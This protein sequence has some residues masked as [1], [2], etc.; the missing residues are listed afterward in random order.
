MKNVLI[1]C[2]ADPKNDPR[3]NRMINWL[4]DDFKLTI[5]TKSAAA[6]E[7]IASIS[8]EAPVRVSKLIKIAGILP[9]GVRKIL[10]EPAKK[11]LSLP[12]MINHLIKIKTGRIEDLLWSIHELTRKMQQQLSDTAFDLII[13][14]DCSLLPLALGLKKKNSK[15]ML[16]AREYYPK[17]YDDQWK[18]RLQQRPINEYLCKQYLH[19]CDKIITVSDGLARE[20][21]K[22]YHVQPEVVMSLPAFHDIL[23]A[24]TDGSKIRMIYHG[25][26]SL[27]RR[28][29]VMI[30]LMGHV[31]ERFS[32]D[33]MVMLDKSEYAEKFIS[34][35]RG[36]RNIRLI[37][38][39]SMQQLVPLT[40]TYDI[41]L[42]LC[43]PT[44]LNLKYALPNKL[45]EFIQARLMVAIGPGIEMRKIVEKYD[46]GIV[47]EDFNP[48]SLARKLNSLTT[49]KVMYYKEQSNTAAHELNEETNR[50]RI[51][52]IV[53]DLIGE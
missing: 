12:I 24:K 37:P 1:V 23:P 10:K 42:F 40:N 28:T 3:P 11:I 52:E 15:V 49:Q 41:G 14:H 46:C 32:L 53:C 35:V 45:F 5:I 22:E 13:T 9:A 50:K 44:N 25:W 21:F 31:D 7:G 4:K 51:R 43:P 20:Y 2:E 33:L 16:D 30:D 17:N 39:V 29:E 36:R 27:S 19:Q 18:W 26:A 47:S 38:T 48:E 6:L 8:A 34:M